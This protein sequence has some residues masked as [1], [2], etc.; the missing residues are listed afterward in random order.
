MNTVLIIIAILLALAGL[1]GSVLPGIPGPPLSWAALLVLSFHPS[2]T[3][4]TAMIVIMAVMAA[5]ITVM[6]Y[7]I[8]GIS[9]KKF[10]GSK[11]GVWGC[12]IGLILSFIGLPFGPQG[13]LGIIIWPFLG[14]LTGE[15]IVSRDIKVSSKSALGAF[16]GFRGGTGFKLIFAVAVIFVMIMQLF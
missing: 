2:V 11:A 16:V 8:P 7:I 13:L 12:N 9:T 5:L 15:M 1:A 10:G 6:D 3:F 14:A 4:G